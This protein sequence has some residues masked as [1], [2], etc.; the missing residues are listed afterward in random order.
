[1]SPPLF[2]KRF[3]LIGLLLV[4]SF[5]VNAEQT[6]LTLQAAT[7]LVVRDNPDL[8]QMQARAT[9][10]AAIPSQEGTLPDPQIS[11]NAMSLPVNTFN[12][13]QEDM[14]QLGVGVS[15]MIPFP[16]K[17]ALREQA[18]L[19]EAEAATQNIT[20]VRQR[21]LSEVKNAWW[22]I[23]YLDHALVLVDSNHTALQQFVEIAQTK[24][25][26]GIG[27]QQD[28]LLAQLELSKLLDQQL[29]LK[30]SR[31]NAAASLN[32][33]LAKPANNEVQLPETIALKLPT[34]K[35]E[36][37]LYQ[38][39]ETTR[40]VLESNRQT[41]QAAESRLA[42]AKKDY[43]PDFTVD[44]SYGARANTLTGDRRSDLLSLSVSMNVPIFAA[45]KQAKAVDQRASELMKEKY[46]LQDEWNK[47]RSQ[48][49]QAY[50]DYQRTKDQFVLYDTGIVPQARQT[51]ASMLAG[52]QVNK[53]DFLNL[54]RSQI[55]LFEY[56][57]QYWK[58]FTEANQALAQLTAAVGKEEI[59]E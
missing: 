31:R 34:L 16:G 53:V 55:T 40:A 52:Y 30:G 4:H 18:A 20:E 15:Q 56:Q 57:I 13:R 41:I 44:A 12:T 14:T 5:T 11:I 46:A 58:A 45:Q 21:L 48:I 8:A 22:L 2:L 19:F 59:Y 37:A 10:M 26:V 3:A 43:L 33:L 24:Y 23:F 25:K 1:M 6:V 29:M 54:A 38:A 17:L 39:A 27:L 9:A 47:V 51:V 42:L 50:T 32:A 7:E 36:T 28:V 35:Q 49:T